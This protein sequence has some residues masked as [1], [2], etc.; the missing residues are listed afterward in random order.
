MLNLLRDGWIPTRRTSGARDIIRPSQV[1]DALSVDPVNALDW[2]RADFRIASLEFLIGLLATACPPESYEAWHDWWDEPPS[3]ETLDAAFAPIA[4]AFDL[5]GNGPRF[6]QDFEDLVSDSEPVERLLIESPGGS[7]QTKNTDLLV[8]RDRFRALGR[9]A[10][11]MALHTFQSW[12]P[13]GGAGNRTGLRGG[14]PLITLVVPPAAVEG[15]PLRLWHLLWANVPVGGRAPTADEL[16]RVFPWLA[17]TVESDG[18]RTVMPETDAHPL[19]CWWGMPRRIRLDFS[20]ATEP[21]PCDITGAPD[22]VQ[23]TGWRQRPRGA[24]Y[25]GWGKVHPLTPHYTAKPGA[26][27]LAVHPQPG[28]IGYRHWLG[29][30]TKDAAGLRLP[31]ASVA[32][33]HDHAYRAEVVRPREARLLAAGYDMDN[34]KARG[35]VEHEMPLPGLTTPEI[36]AALDGLA[37]TLVL[38]ADAV[39]ALLRSAIRQA[40]FSAGAT[41]KLDAELLSATRERLWDATEQPFFD[42]L[43]GLAAGTSSL[44]SL[45]ADWHARLRRTALEL[46]DET[47]PIDPDVAATGDARRIAAARRRF[48][49]TLAGYGKE[50]AA[51]FLTLG[52]APPETKAARKGKST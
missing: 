18:N 15:Q 35:F 23:V 3:V 14:G 13:A 33:W 24:N 36:R 7:T 5:D 22:T 26:E 41:V 19:Q 10:A 30:V 16:P 25:A 38:S 28:G 17:P 47:A 4:H 45:C 37:S 12:A 32:E 21:R 40:L 42:A 51:L 20:A 8:R 1:I 6:L 31:A 46:F 49:F 27:W 34:M 9:P 2:P 44:G 48:S 43:S 11:A 52:L 39:A 29:L 50:G